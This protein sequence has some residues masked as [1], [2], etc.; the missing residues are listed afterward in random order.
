RMQVAGHG[1]SLFRFL[2]GAYRNAI[3]EL[4]GSLSME[5][6]KA[7]SERIALIDSIISGQ[8]ALARLREMDSLALAA[9]GS[10]WRKE[11]T[12]WNQLEI[13][14]KWVTRQNQAGLGPSFRQ[15]YAGITDQMRVA[16]L[17]Q[18]LAASLT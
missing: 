16:G 11:K 7:Y 6:P 12:D 4:R 15:M 13:I 1:K 3:A 17:L 8:Q 18:K 10:N 5:L 9:F 2:N 14:L